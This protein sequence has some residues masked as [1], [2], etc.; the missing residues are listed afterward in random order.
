MKRYALILA[1]VLLAAPQ[2]RVFAGQPDENKLFTPAFFK[3]GWGD[4]KE[5]PT[6][7]FHWEKKEWFIAGG[8]LGASLTAIAFDGK[9]QT[10]YRDHRSGFFTSVSD[11]TTHF[12]DY[13]QQVPILMGTWI[14]GLAT[15][16]ET[17]NKIAA[18]G[19][20]ASIIAAGIITP[21]LVYCTGRALPNANEDPQKFRP[22]V[23]MRYSYP[24]GHTTAAFSLATVLDQDLREKFGY[25]HTPIVYG[26]A[27]GTATS[28]IYDDTHY[29][30]DV[31]LGAGIGWS[32]GYWISN[33][34]RNKDRTVW[35]IPTT[36]GVM[37]TAKF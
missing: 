13:K 28:R 25:W 1:A 21:T 4:L 8:V 34:P 9:V 26:M 3:R 7:P 37:L 36:D 6:K 29:L 18:D 11:V 15:G 20:E 2:V 33:K 16:N 27:V 14:A 5:L 17:L 24:S 30:S 12:G 32:V 31:I 35:I 10:Y 22:F 19:A 23:P